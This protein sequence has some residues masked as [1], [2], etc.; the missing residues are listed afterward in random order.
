MAE[1]KKDVYFEALIESQ[2]SHK[3]ALQDELE[4]ADILTDK[5]MKIL[6]TPTEERIFLMAVNKKTVPWKEIAKEL[7]ITKMKA[8]WYVEKI[9]RRL[10]A[11]HKFLENF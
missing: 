10:S 5:L 3:E 7:E 2:L 9:R 1:Y 4:R 6:L 11:F 8:V